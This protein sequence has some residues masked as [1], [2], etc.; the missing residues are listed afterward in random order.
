[1]H[2]D[3][4]FFDTND[5]TC[6]STYGADFLN[7]LQIFLTKTIPDP[8]YSESGEKL[9]GQK[10]QLDLIQLFISKQSSLHVLRA[11][12][13]SLI[14]RYHQKHC[15]S[16]ELKTSDLNRCLATLKQSIGTKAQLANFVFEDNF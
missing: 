7:Q 10:S 13:P 9:E 8:E 12:E 4:G 16:Q 2:K 15:D 3:N 5:F 14:V 6:F 11:I 1:M